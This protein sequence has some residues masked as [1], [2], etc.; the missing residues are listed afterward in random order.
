MCSDVNKKRPEENQVV[1]EPIKIKT[2]SE[3]KNKKQ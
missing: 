1:M 3:L 2:V